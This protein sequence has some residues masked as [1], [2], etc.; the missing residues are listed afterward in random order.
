L[1]EK[2]LKEIKKHNEFFVKKIKKLEEDG[3]FLAV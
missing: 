2:E 1:P 3:I